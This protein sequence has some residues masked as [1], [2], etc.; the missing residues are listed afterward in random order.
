MTLLSFLTI[1][2]AS[3]HHNPSVLPFFIVPTSEPQFA[4]SCFLQASN[5]TIISI[6]NLL[7]DVYQ[8]TPYLSG[9]WHP[10]LTAEHRKFM[11]QLRISQLTDAHKIRLCVRK[12]NNGVNNM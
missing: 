12:T 1:N 9:T 3:A 5:P 4:S 2:N 8:L 6:L 10:D 7:I 11:P